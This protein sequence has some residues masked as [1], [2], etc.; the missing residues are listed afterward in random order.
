MFLIEALATTDLDAFGEFLDVA[1]LEVGVFAT[2]DSFKTRSYI[3][4]KSFKAVIKRYQSPS[5]TADE[6]IP[7]SAMSIAGGGSVE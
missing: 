7:P 4:P 5:N 1:F 2:L 6:F 3:A